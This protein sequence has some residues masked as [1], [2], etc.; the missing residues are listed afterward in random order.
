MGQPSTVLNSKN[1]ETTQNEVW[2]FVKIVNWCGNIHVIN[3]GEVKNS[4]TILVTKSER[5]KSL[6]RPRKRQ[7]ILKWILM[8]YTVL[9]MFGFYELQNKILVV[10]EE[11]ISSPAE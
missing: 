9:H 10:T 7:K 6:G 3:K 1:T 11:G 8:K 5:K 4:H 2:A